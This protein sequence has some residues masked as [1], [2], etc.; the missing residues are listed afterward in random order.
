MK[1]R[2]TGRR[3]KLTSICRTRAAA[4][5]IATDGTQSLTKGLWQGVRTEGDAKCRTGGSEVVLQLI[6]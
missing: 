1:L 6:V 3:M 4:R 2:Q 5:A